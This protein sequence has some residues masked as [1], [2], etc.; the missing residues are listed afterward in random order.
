MSDRRKY[1]PS[2]K[3]TSHTNGSDDDYSPHS[4]RDKFRRERSMDGNSYMDTYS[5]KTDEY[6]RYSRNKRYIRSPSPTP[7]QRRKYRRTSPDHHS[8]RSNYRRQSREHTEGRDSDYAVD[9][10]VPNYERDG[11]TPGARYGRNAEPKQQQQQQQSNYNPGYKNHHPSTHHLQQQSSPQ[12]SNY[13]LMETMNPS[14]AG[15]NWSSMSRITLI[16]PLQLEYVVPFK[17]YR[18]YLR[19]TQPKIPFTDEDLQ[20]EYDDYK[21]KMGTK[22]LALFFFNNKEKQWFLEKYHPQASTLRVDDVKKRRLYNF[23]KFMQ[24]LQ[25]GEFDRIQHDAYEGNTTDMNDSDDNNMDNKSLD[26]NSTCSNESYENQLVIKAVPPT[27]PR[28]KII[29]MCN[30]VDGFEYLALSEP[31]VTK[32]FHRIGWIHFSEETDMQ[33]VFDQ[34]DNQKIDDFTFHLAMN[35]KNQS[36][37]GRTGRFAPD[38]TSTM[39]RLSLDLDQATR[40][41]KLMD[42]ELEKDGLENVIERARQL[43]GNDNDDGSKLTNTKKELDLILTYLRHVHMYCYYC[44]LECDSMEELNRRCLDP[45]NRRLPSG[46]T[47]DSKQALKHERISQQWTKNL[48][49]RI[50]M[51]INPPGD[52][53]DMVKLGGKSLKSELDAYMEEH[54]Q[55]EHDAKYKCKVGDCSKAFKGIEF[56]EKHITTKHG[57]EIQRIKD[58]VVFYNNYVCDPNHLLPCASGNGG[59]LVMSPSGLQTA[60]MGTPWEQIPRI[61][62]GGNVGWPTSMAGRISGRKGLAQQTPDLSDMMMVDLPQDP[63]QVKSYVDLD[64]PAT[65]DAN[66]S[67][68]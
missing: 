31:G 67:F 18:E 66:I 63:R 45:H 42:T 26:N 58:E 43:V 40:L 41:A 30:K 6:G 57:D 14:M 7:D 10:Y 27:I 39:E 62:F 2:N 24:S 56:V 35:R 4:S 48:D 32:K 19:Q 55:K 11:Y 54:I 60:S 61:G 52:D 33:K 21:E 16:D 65:G 64:A 1:S 44:A 13:S 20:K 38:I 36:T 46:S 47:S 22:Q 15:G 9:H 28:Q 50:G 59:S 68:Y 25:Q 17:Q 12:K 49:Q 5:P 53:E 34:L 51:K 8:H 29:D 3:S 23:T 37:S